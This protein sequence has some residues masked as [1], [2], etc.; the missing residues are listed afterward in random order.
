L[1][2][3]SNTNEDEETRQRPVT[4]FQRPSL[5]SKCTRQMN[6]LLVLTKMRW[7]TSFDLVVLKMPFMEL[8]LP[9]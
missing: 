3:R 9:E 5:S 8:L 7:T 2:K 4:F 6:D 1:N